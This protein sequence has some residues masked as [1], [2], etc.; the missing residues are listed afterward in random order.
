[1]LGEV[2][3]EQLRVRE[4]SGGSLGFRELLERTMKKASSKDDESETENH[5]DEAG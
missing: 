2:P 4:A 3:E 1:M 5:E